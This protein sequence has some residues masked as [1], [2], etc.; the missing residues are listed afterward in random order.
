MTETIRE[1]T[2][3]GERYRE[4]LVPR[5]DINDYV[6]VFTSTWED[7]VVSVDYNDDDTYTIILA[8]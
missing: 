5:S 4:V 1:F 6:N 2:D 3:G 8:R 7:D